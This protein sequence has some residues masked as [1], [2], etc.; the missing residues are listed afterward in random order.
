MML[1][2][3]L[4]ILLLIT[5]IGLIVY[6]VKGGNLLVGFLVMSVL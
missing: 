6:C 5:F 2:T 1:N 4:G 3:I